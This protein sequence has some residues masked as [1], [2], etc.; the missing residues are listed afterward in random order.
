MSNRQAPVAGHAATGQ[1]IMPC[2][3]GKDNFRKHPPK[4]DYLDAPRAVSGDAASRRGGVV[5]GYDPT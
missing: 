1:F 5:A 3:E 2:D 4:G